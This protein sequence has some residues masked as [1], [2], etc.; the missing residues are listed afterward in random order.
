MDELKQ[1]II[2]GIIKQ[3]K[4]AGILKVID[5]EK[6]LFKCGNTTYRFFY[7]YYDAAKEA[8]EIVEANELNEYSSY[9][10]NDINNGVNKT[11]EDWKDWILDGGGVY[12]VLGSW[13]GIER[14]I[15]I[16][17]EKYYYCRI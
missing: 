10:E 8:R 4:L 16:D 5:E 11:Y 2:E 14:T 6:N 15:E 12:A 17:G 13:D 7:S 3:E 1:K 9:Y